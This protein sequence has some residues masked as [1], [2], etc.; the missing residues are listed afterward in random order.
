[1][2]FGLRRSEFFSHTASVALR[3]DMIVGRQGN[4]SRDGVSVVGDG[5]QKER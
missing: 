3:K 4:K 1:M 5:S 2:S